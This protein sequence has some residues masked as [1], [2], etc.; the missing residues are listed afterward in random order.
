LREFQ[1][2]DGVR[3]VKL[4]AAAKRR[5]VYPIV[6]EGGLELSAI[7]D[8]EILGRL[9]E[10][11]QCIVYDA[12][13]RGREVALKLYK[14][15]AVDRHFACTGGELAQY[16]FERNAALRSVPGLEP[17]VAEPLAFHA[18]AGISAFVQERLYGELYYDHYVRCE[19]RVDAAIRDRLGEV[20][21]GAH[22]A[23]LYDLD[24][25]AGNTMLVADPDTGALSPKLFDFNSIPFYEKPPNPA[26]YI[27][28]RLGL[29]G[30][31]WR[32]EKKLASFH[33]FA[34][35][36]KKLAKFGAPDTRGG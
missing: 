10:G 33:D 24:V 31:A 12:R 22:A 32:D 4:R 35:Y 7:G 2:A 14:A 21:A 36:R 27:A 18:S 16:E 23:G 29:I 6:E 15:A 13:W 3:F 9:G 25:H 1:R 17:N 30:R 34:S 5:Q 19:G 11:L 8:V 20:L 26:V 28:F